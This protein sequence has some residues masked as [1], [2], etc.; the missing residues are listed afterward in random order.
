M[1]DFLKEVNFAISV[2]NQDGEIIYLNKKGSE[3]FADEGG[4]DLIGSNILD[5]HPEPSRSQLEE[6]M[7]SHKT[8][9]YIKGEGLDKRLIYQTP[10]YESAIFRGYIECI[11]P[12]AEV[13]EIS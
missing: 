11:I 6:M 9:A 3:T 4:M 10:I 5:C 12:L 2:C 7:H 13:S 1:Y 8:N